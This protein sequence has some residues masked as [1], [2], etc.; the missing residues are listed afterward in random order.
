MTITVWVLTLNGAM[1]PV[2]Y[3]GGY[4][5]YL[6]RI[7]AAEAAKAITEHD[8]EYIEERGGEIKLKEVTT[9]QF[10]LESIGIFPYKED[11]DEL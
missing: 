6:T 2:G 1:Y 10:V 9:D 3:K 5:G 7:A 11:Q 8:R 4:P